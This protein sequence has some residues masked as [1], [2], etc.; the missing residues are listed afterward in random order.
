ML[1]S[2][3]R[4]NYL[5][6]IETT[7][8]TTSTTHLFVIQ[9][10]ALF[11]SL[12][13]QFIVP[14]SLFVYFLF[15]IIQRMMI[16]MIVIDM[17]DKWIKIMQSKRFIRSLKLFYFLILAAAIVFIFIL[18]PWG[19]YSFILILSNDDMLWYHLF[20]SLLCYDC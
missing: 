7:T 13:I 6:S 14:L 15:L 18:D 11:K 5:M 4:I 10:W 3:W 20:L 17:I 2:V 9:F 1:F 16:I 12:F 19:V 8:M